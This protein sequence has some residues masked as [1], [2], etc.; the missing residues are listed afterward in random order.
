MTFYILVVLLVTRFWRSQ[1]SVPDQV[2]E[3]YAREAEENQHTQQDSERGND[4]IPV[5]FMPLYVETNNRQ[6]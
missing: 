1:Y 2:Q 6:L 5:L 4:Q 3:A